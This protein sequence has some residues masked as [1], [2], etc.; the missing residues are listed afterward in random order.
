MQPQAT[1]VRP[2]QINNKSPDQQASC[3]WLVLNMPRCIPHWSSLATHSD[4]NR[5]ASTTVSHACRSPHARPTGRAT[6]PRNAS[7]PLRA[8]NLSVPSEPIFLMWLPSV[9]QGIRLS[10]G[11]GA[12]SWQLQPQ[13]PTPSQLALCAYCHREYYR[14]GRKRP[15]SCEQGKFGSNLRPQIG[16]AR[17]SSET[18]QVLPGVT[19]DVV[20]P[21]TPCPASCRPSR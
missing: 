20:R 21:T 10:N 6:T 14:L 16:L 7:T 2:A 8:D 12:V 15:D 19:V 4:T 18:F 1:L 9:P 3:L 11:Q 17:P 5:G 13:A